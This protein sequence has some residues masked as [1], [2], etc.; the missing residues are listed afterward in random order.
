MQSM[1]GDGKHSV[2]TGYYHYLSFFKKRFYLF[3]FRQRER[4]EERGNINVW[5]PLMQPLLGTWSTTQACALTGNQTNDPLVH[6]LELNPLSHTSQSYLS[7]F[8]C[9]NARA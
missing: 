3:I 6:R 1:R 8:V 7:F 9:I 4:E 2:N 5:L